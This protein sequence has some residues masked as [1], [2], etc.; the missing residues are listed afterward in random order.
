MKIVDYHPS[1]G[2]PLVR[3]WRESFE[4]AVGVKD[5]HSIEEQIEYLHNIVLPKNTVRIVVDDDSD[6]IV[7]FLAS[8]SDTIDQLYIHVDHQGRGIGTVLLNLAKR[9]SAGR[10]RRTLSM[11]G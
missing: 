6:E 3:M 2:L 5:T 11:N 4:R 7:G 1:M 10:L 9:D 8:N